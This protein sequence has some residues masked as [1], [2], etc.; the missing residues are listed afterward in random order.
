MSEQDKNSAAA[1]DPAAG[2]SAGEAT[3]AAARDTAA[4][5]PSEPPARRSRRRVTTQPVPGSDPNPAP[6]APRHTLEENDDRLKA[7]KPPHY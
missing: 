1:D 4:G 6:E 5:A 2:T 7:E 3:R